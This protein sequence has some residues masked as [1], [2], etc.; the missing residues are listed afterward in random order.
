MDTRIWMQESF[1]ES[2]EKQ[3]VKESPQENAE[4]LSKDQN[5]NGGNKLVD[6]KTSL[7]KQ[8]YE[9]IL[10]GMGFCVI[11]LNFLLLYYILPFIGILMIFAGLRKLKQE[12]KWFKAGYAAAAINVVITMISI[13]SGTFINRRQIYDTYIWQ[14]MLLWTFALP[15]IIA[16]CFFCGMQTE[17]KKREKEAD[18]KILI[19]LVIWYAVVILLMNMNDSGW[20]I[21]IA[22]L[23]TYIG[24][25]VE[26]KHTAEN[27]EKAGYVLEESPMRVSNGKCAAGAVVLT[28]AG[29]VIGTIFF[30]SYHMR[31]N[32]VKAPQD[33]A[34]EEIKTHLVSIGFPEDILDDLKEE[35]LLAC[36][37]ARQVRLQQTDYP[38]NDGE[39]IVTRSEGYTQYSREYPHKELRLS[40][41]AVELEQEGHWKIIHHFLWNEDPGFRGTEAL[42]LYPACRERNGG[43]LEEGGLTGQVLY[44]KKEISYAAD[45]ASLENETY[46]MGQSWPFYESRETSSIFAEFS[47]PWRGERCRGY[48][49][50]GIREKEKDWW[51]DSWLNY[52]HQK[53]ILQYPV[54]TAAQN[55]KQGGWLD[56]L[57]FFT[58]QDALQVLPGEETD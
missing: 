54:M 56:N 10:V 46:D 14:F 35:D 24:I 27:L 57:V 11:K 19:H 2:A 20:I 25:L 52:T 53:S 42:Q 34:Y 39:Q 28:A 31:W 12:D 9:N 30:G 18:N 49:S 4:H 21:G 40:G 8:T 15:L 43:W 55:R 32:E 38:I 48:V 50:Y 5:E 29:L 44:D 36:K 3:S 37:N 26:L 1:W 51:I 17:L 58:V 6:Q 13:V 41:I 23:A 7:W 45:Y 33:P 22:V 47:M 16:S